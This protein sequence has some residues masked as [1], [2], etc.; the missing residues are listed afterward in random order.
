MKLL[1]SR[2]KIVC[3][4]YLLIQEYNAKYLTQQSRKEAINVK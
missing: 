2:C 4:L 1:I 3:L